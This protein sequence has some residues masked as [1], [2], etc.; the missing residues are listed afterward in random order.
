MIRIKNK[1]ALSDIVVSN[2]PVYVETTGKLYVNY[3]GEWIERAYYT[4]KDIAQIINE[5]ESQVRNI[6]R[7]L[8]IRTKIMSGSNIH[9]Q[10]ILKIIKAVSMKKKRG[11][12]YA[13]IKKELKC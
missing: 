3:D 6:I 1:F 13:E 4:T 5:D 8:N 9:Y 12:T 2:E 11:K 10:D 7:K